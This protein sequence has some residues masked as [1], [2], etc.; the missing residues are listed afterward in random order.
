[1][2]IRFRHFS[3]GWVWLVLFLPA[4]AFGPKGQ[5]VYHWMVGHIPRV[6][7]DEAMKD[8]ELPHANPAFSA[9]PV[10]EE[11]Y[12][13]LPE[14]VI[15]RTYPVY[16]PDHEP[17]G[18]WEWLHE[19][20]A[21]VVFDEAQLVTEEDW[22]Q[23][24][25]LL[26]D[27]PIDTLGAVINT[28]HVRNRAFFET[29]AMPVTSEGILPFA[30]WVVAGK[31]KVYLGNLS[32]GM[33][34]TRVMDDGSLLK[35]AQG[36]WPGDKAFAFA[37]ESDGVSERGVQ[38]VTNF[39]FGSPFAEGDPHGKLIES[40]REQILHAYK[41]VPEGA[42]GR[43]GTSILYPPQAPNLIGVKDRK[44]LDHGGLGQHRSIED[45]MRYIAMN[46]ALDFLNF[47]GDY[48]PL[49]L[50]RERLNSGDP[51]FFPGTYDRHSDA[52]LYAIAKYVYSLQAPENPNKPS[53]ISERGK[54]I[55][56]DQG[57]VTC[58]TPPLF[59]NN[60]LTPA[61]GFYIPD[62]HYDTYDIFDISVGTDPGYTMHTRRGTGYYK[63]PSLLGLWYRGPFLHDASLARLEDLFDPRR[64]EDD[65][66]PTGFKPHD[67]ETK[68]VLGHEFGLDLSESDQAAL[69]AY[70]LTL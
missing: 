18:Y 12:Y 39:L 61:D 41:A 67:V 34:H 37:L 47:Y 20:E 19:Q 23:A 3:L 27:Y 59:T 21:E 1:M 65:Y 69:I 33:C 11:F 49:G 14:R 68:A 70:L 10:S 66:V 50:T 45:L 7:T 25:E 48:N 42:F 31:G 26:F 55:F 13:N 29:T 8:W 54:V 24:G 64:L 5:L 60:K 22:V 52:Q 62:R 16:H 38:G 43:Q 30:K 4:F 32:C 40:G 15:Y 17:E 35:G 28:Q 63:V 36:N 9:E 51:I 58:H 46:Q 2:K 56:A 57:C 44:Y 6:W 53:E